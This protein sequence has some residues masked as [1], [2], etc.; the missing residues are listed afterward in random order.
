MIEKERLQPLGLIDIQKTN[1]KDPLNK[2]SVKGLNLLSKQVAIHLF[3][4]SCHYPLINSTNN[5]PTM[6]VRL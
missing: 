2:P 3:P 5:Y 1:L 4:L 6:C